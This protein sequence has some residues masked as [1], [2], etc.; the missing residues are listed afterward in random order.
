MSKETLEILKKTR[1][2]LK[3]RRA[4][5]KQDIAKNRSNLKL[6]GDLKIEIEELDEE[7][8]ECEKDIQLLE[9]EMAEE[10]ETKDSSTKS[11]QYPPEYDSYGNFQDRNYLPPRTTNP[12]I[13]SSQ[14]LR[15][16]LFEVDHLINEIEN[17]SHSTRNQR[18]QY[19]AEI[20]EMP[21]ETIGY[22]PHQDTYRKPNQDK[23]I[24]NYEQLREY[25]EAGQWKEADIETAKVILKV[26][27]REK[28][29]WLKP[30][31][32]ENFP[33]KDLKIINNLWLNKS[34]GHFG[35]SVQ[36]DLWLS[37]GGKKGE[38]NPIL[39][40]QFG[41]LVG[42]YQNEEWLKHEDFTFDLQ[43]RRGHL[44]SLQF[45]IAKD[46]DEEEELGIWRENF[47]GFLSRCEKCR[48][49]GN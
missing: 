27:K 29:G 32:I 28:E 12:Q 21:N 25:L 19:D 11:R 41:E 22:Q 1:D 8:E 20:L 14:R 13:S 35:F 34:K 36:R 24:G 6:I 46:P 38:F 40:Y 30:K 39:Y 9:A 4:Q 2:T 48:I 33:C 16:E 17:F 18:I 49:D 43:A 31:D 44:P 5:Y 7:I 26:A 42:W 47:K 15:D 3:R 45:S 23:I 10:A 37:I